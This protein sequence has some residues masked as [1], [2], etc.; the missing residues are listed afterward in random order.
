MFRIQK[1]A[2]DYDANMG[3]EPVYVTPTSA[4]RRYNNNS[5]QSNVPS[6]NSVRKTK[7]KQPTIEN[8]KLTTNQHN[9]YKSKLLQVQN[10]VNK[11]VTLIENNSSIKELAHYKQLTQMLKQSVQPLVVRD[12]QNN[13]PNKQPQVPK[14]NIQPIETMQKIQETQETQET[15]EKTQNIGETTATPSPNETSIQAT[16][17]DAQLTTLLD[18]LQEKEQVE[19]RVIENIFCQSQD[20]VLEQLVLQSEL[21]LTPYQQQMVSRWTCF[22]NWMGD[23]HINSSQQYQDLWQNYTNRFLKETYNITMDTLNP[24]DDLL[25]CSVKTGHNLLSYA[26]WNNKQT[27]CRIIPFNRT[28]YK[29]HP[30]MLTNIDDSEDVIVFNQDR[31]W[32]LKQHNQVWYQIDGI[33]GVT[34]SHSP[35]HCFKVDNV[36]MILPIAGSDRLNQE[37]QQLKKML[38]KF[39]LN[40][41]LVEQQISINQIEKIVDRI[42]KVRHILWDLVYILRDIIG[43]FR[44]TH[45]YDDLVIT[46]DAFLDKFVFQP[47]DVSNI[48]HGI[49]DLIIMILECDHV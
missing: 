22:N 23:Y 42:L 11:L 24:W 8:Q 47:Q 36:G 28:Q 43:L 44:V 16:Q 10:E 14:N 4:H 40:T 37:F 29:N 3:P 41:G 45:S 6:I 25:N 15:Q 19:F 5:N 31:C 48:K 39:L 34:R 21:E 46:F 17:L 12:H 9:A 20:Q 18:Q 1:S 33:T 32:V 26:L 38:Q 7:H 27:Y 49:P 35:S 13:P 30:Y 2:A